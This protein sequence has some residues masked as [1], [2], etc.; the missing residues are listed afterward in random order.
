VIGGDLDIGN[1]RIDSF[2]FGKCEK[3][4]EYVKMGWKMF[5]HHFISVTVFGN[6]EKDGKCQNII[7]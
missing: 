3:M 4:L 1:C 5:K 2:N 6:H 7:L